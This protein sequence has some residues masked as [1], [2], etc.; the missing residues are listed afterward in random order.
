MKDMNNLDSSL[1]YETL[2]FASAINNA[3]GALVV[4]VDF[5]KLGCLTTKDLNNCVDIAKKALSAIPERG[6]CLALAPQILSE[7]RSGLREEWRAGIP[8]PKINI[9]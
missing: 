1:S 3:N 8:T 6:V 2:Q 4:W 7:K 5:M 9:C